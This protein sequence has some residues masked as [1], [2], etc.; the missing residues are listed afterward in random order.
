MKCIV[1][2]GP[3]ICVDTARHYLRATY[4]PPAAQGDVYLAV[5]D[6]AQ[7]IGIVDGYFQGVPSVWHKEI[8][9]AMSQ[10]VHVFG[11]AS[12]GALRAAELHT[13]G[14]H[15]IGEIFAHFRDGMLTDDDEVAVLHGP[16][17]MCYRAQTVPLVNI[18][19]TL[20][21]AQEQQVI[22][23][24]VHNLMIEA[25]SGLFYWQRSYAAL[26]EK[27]AGRIDGE[28][29]DR[30]RD[31]LV[32]HSIDQ[33]CADAI[34]MLKCMDCVKSAPRQV[35][36]QFQHTSAWEDLIA[37]V[38]ADPQASIVR[39]MLSPANRVIDELRLNSGHYAQALS[40]IGHTLQGPVPATESSNRLLAYLR[41]TDCYDQLAKR[42][43]NKHSVLSRDYGR[44]PD[45]ADAMLQPADVLEWYFE[46]VCARSVPLDLD[47]H[48]ER[49]GMKNASELCR[50]LLHELLYVREQSVEQV[51]GAPL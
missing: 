22:N 17:E 21:L 10:G 1:F 51:N 42:A 29:L 33:K 3:T 48:A 13:F 14:M 37:S 23:H 18:R 50:L 43:A 11:S 31:W 38:D 24:K 32:D 26:I 15:G 2:L 39:D 47:A 19:A 12:M 40:T 7:I 27:C 34:E 28:I 20:R 30:C 45:F 35:D 5:R 4:L 9:W 36:Y 41:E 6:G 46:D 16:E 44:L 8:L 25:A 49:L